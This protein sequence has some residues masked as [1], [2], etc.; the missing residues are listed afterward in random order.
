MAD[1]VSIQPAQVQEIII[2][3]APAQVSVADVI[4]NGRIAAVAQRTQTEEQRRT[5]V[6]EAERIRVENE[7]KA[8]TRE[9]KIKDFKRQTRILNNICGPFAEY[10]KFQ[11]GINPEMRVI[12]D[13][14]QWMIMMLAAKSAI[15]TMMEDNYVDIENPPEDVK[16]AMGTIYNN[17]DIVSQSFTNS[18]NQIVS[19][20]QNQIIKGSSSVNI[21]KVDD[22]I[23]KPLNEIVTILRQECNSSNNLNSDQ[24][25][26]S[27]LSAMTNNVNARRL[28][29]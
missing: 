10:M 7:E 1:N 5:R 18:M 24:S 21:D 12:M 29:N 25:T 17:I 20:M 2:S 23:R 22:V 27:V 6:A 16:T 13:I 15:T 19:M 3:P 26:P 9:E 11:Q 14:N 4:E 28:P 8:K